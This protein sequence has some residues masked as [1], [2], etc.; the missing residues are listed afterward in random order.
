[1]EVIEW[2]SGKDAS[3]PLFECAYGSI[4]FIN[5]FFGCGYFN[6]SIFRQLLYSLVELHAHE[7]SLYYHDTFGI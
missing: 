3:G 4:N 5:M 6:D 7:G 1:M 2:H